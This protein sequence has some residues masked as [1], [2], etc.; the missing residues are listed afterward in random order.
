MSDLRRML[1]E[2]RRKNLRRSIMRRR[3]LA[4]RRR[5]GPHGGGGGADSGQG[6]VDAPF[7]EAS[8]TS[9]GGFFRIEMSNPDNIVEAVEQSFTA[10][11]VNTS[12]G[13]YITLPD[14]GFGAFPS[15][16]SAS[17]NRCWFT[18]G[19]TLPAPLQLGTIYYRVDLGGNQARFYKEATDADWA[20]LPGATQGEYVRPAQRFAQAVD[21]VVFTDGGSGVHTMHTHPLTSEM[22]SAVPGKPYSAAARLLVDRNSWGEIETD[23]QG[24]KFIWSEKT[25]S[26]HN[27]GVYRGYGKFY[28]LGPTAQRLNISSETAVKRWVWEIAIVLPNVGDKEFERVP[29]KMGFV[30][31]TDVNTTTNTFTKTA[32]PF[33]TANMVKFL[34]WPGQ[35]LP[36]G[37][38]AGTAYYTRVTGSAF[39]LHPTAAD[40]NANTNI[41][42]I[43]ST[44]GNFSLYTPLLVG[45]GLRWRFPIELI[46]P[47][48]GGG[49]VLSPRAD[50]E[51]HHIDNSAVTVSGTGA[52][53]MNGLG[54]IFPDDLTYVYVCFP[55]EAVG[56]TCVD[57]GLPLASGYYWETHSPGSA[58]LARLHRTR[59][60]ALESVGVATNLSSCIKFNAA[61]LGEIQ[62]YH[63]DGSIYWTFN[64]DRTAGLAPFNNR[65]LPGKLM[66]LVHSVDYNNPTATGVVVSQ[67]IDEAVTE[68]IDDGVTPKGL[69]DAAIL[70]SPGSLLGSGASHVA[71]S[72][73]MYAFYAGA[74]TT[75]PDFD[76]LQDIVDYCITRYRI[77]PYVPVAVGIPSISGNLR[78]AQTLTATP[79]TF[80]GT[81]PITTTWRWERD[82]VP[83]AG[84]TSSTY[85]TVAADETHTLTVVQIGTNAGGPTESESVAT[86][87]ILEAATPPV[88]TVAPTI[89]ASPA[90][91]ISQQCNP[92]TWTGTAPI[93]YAYQWQQ[94]ND[95][96]GSGVADISG[97]TAQN[98]TPLGAQQTKF[99]RCKVTAT[100]EHSSVVV[101]TAY[102]SAVA[103]RPPN[104]A[105]TT[106]LLARF[107]VAPVEAHEIG[108]NQCIAKL[109]TDGVWAKLDMLHQFE[110]NTGMVMADALLDWKATRSATVVGTVSLISKSGIKGNGVSG[111]YVDTT[112]N[113]TSP[114][115]NWVQ[116]SCTLFVRMADE[117]P[118]N[119]K[120]ISFN[121]TGSR[122]YIIPRTI[123]DGFNVLMQANTGTYNEVGTVTVG[124][125]FHAA[126]RSSSSTINI[127]FN[128]T[129][130][131]THSQTSVSVASQTF[132]F[133]SDAGT[134][135]H[136]GLIVYGG[137]GGAMTATDLDNLYDACEAYKDLVASL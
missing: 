4:R 86:G 107:S 104:E 93:T 97:A 16:P 130:R 22:M 32:H 41:V 110:V 92:G 66:A 82:G 123:S 30:G 101:F 95:A 68:N 51:N 50:Q 77:V 87:V 55:P 128:K 37:V 3:F 46:E 76:L 79:T 28:Q 58:V 74:T 100:N 52:G 23:A 25:A 17:G 13:G 113:P 38:T 60:S 111:S 102:S 64:Y 91:G 47:G 134:S 10:A 121:L 34:Q 116:N 94:A 59:A 109:K 33:L 90:V 43:T 84:A 136:P 133:M 6:E 7:P 71:F 39:T 1:E 105:E 40:A 15:Y 129:A 27:A 62:F 125:G 122:A 99:L 53:N 103:A 117:T 49:N 29:S 18:S 132:R 118:S 80:T 11:D 89:P 19:G 114:V 83:I 36:G 124:Q 73:R 112:V 45:D 127:R 20:V 98:F 106:A 115:G 56:P 119:A 2:E 69:T 137:S 48:A 61:G 88:N 54:T 12:G 75:A 67:G 63:G 9:L 14:M 70:Q 8:F 5:M 42:D 108:I 81:L 120:A 24:R 78:V 21:W 126:F 85:F 57:T 26:D 135:C 65:V 44:G 131:A 72:G 31:S 35:S 96:G